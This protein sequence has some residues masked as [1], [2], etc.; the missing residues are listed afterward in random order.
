[1][2]ATTIE[3]ERAARVEALGEMLTEFAELTDQV[4]RLIPDRYYRMDFD[5]LSTRVCSDWSEA[6]AMVE[7]AKFT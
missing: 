6:L 4:A 1:M 3:D 7:G 2:K 5:Q